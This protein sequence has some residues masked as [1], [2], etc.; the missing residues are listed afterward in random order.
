MPPRL[1]LEEVLPLL[2]QGEEEEQGE[3]DPCSQDRLHLVRQK[4]DGHKFV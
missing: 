1:L 3:E 2:Q 4:M